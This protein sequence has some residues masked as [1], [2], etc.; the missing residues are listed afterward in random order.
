MFKVA[1]WPQVIAD[2][3]VVSIVFDQCQVGQKTNHGPAKKSTEVLASSLEL[4]K[5]FVGKVCAGQRT[6]AVLTGQ[7][8]KQAQKWS[9]EMCSRLAYGIERLVVSELKHLRESDFEL[10]PQAPQ[11][12][13]MDQLP[14]THGGENAEAACGVTGVQARCQTLTNSR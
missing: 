7:A 10:K 4:L 2:P 1:P 8:A 6:H 9:H 3:R 13:Q 5:P 12:E 11:T 14:R